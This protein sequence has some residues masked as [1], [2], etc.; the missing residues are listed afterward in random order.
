MAEIRVIYAGV[1]SANKILQKAVHELAHLESIFNYLADIIDPEI[2]MRYQ[3]AEKLRT[4]K[5]SAA[6]VYQTAKRILN[7][8]ETGLLEYQKAETKLNQPITSNDEQF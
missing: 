7:V 4:S 3:I 5:Y 2:Q 8:T 1:W 6:E